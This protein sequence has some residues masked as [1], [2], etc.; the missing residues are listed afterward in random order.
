MTRE[1]AEEYVGT[2]PA[3]SEEEAFREFLEREV[4]SNFRHGGLHVKER[5]AAQAGLVTSSILLV[6]FSFFSASADPDF[7]RHCCCMEYR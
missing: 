6:C 2:S 4:S 1:E 7:A 3:L 5:S